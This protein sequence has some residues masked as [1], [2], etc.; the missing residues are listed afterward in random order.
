MS[1]EE[2]PPAAS[3]EWRGI[4]FGVCVAIIIASALLL[5]DLQEPLGA[6]VIGAFSGIAAG[7]VFQR[8]LQRHGER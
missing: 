5:T 6:S 1:P 4:W 3:T 7:V 8:Y 2:P